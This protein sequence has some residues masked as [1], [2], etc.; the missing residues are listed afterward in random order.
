MSEDTAASNDPAVRWGLPAG[1]RPV[2]SPVPDELKEMLREMLRPNE[3]VIG[4]LGNE[5]DTIFVVA[6]TERLFSARRGATAGVTGWTIKEYE[7][8]DIADLKMQTASMNVRY[9][10]SFHSRDG[11]TP[12]SGPRAKQWKLITDNLAP[13]E[14]ARG[15]EL[16]EAIQSVWIHKTRGEN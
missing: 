10:I 11:R 15:S 2:V 4:A 8:A 14:T 7:W 9:T 16:Y 12:S 5:G 13:F 1:F 3:P 6:S